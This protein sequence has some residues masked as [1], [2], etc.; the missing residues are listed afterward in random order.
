MK[1]AIWETRNFGTSRRSSGNRQR[2]AAG[3]KTVLSPLVARNKDGLTGP[4]KEPRHKSLAG[5]PSLWLMP[6]D[7][8]VAQ[9]HLPFFQQVREQG[10]KGRAQA[11]VG[12]G[13]ELHKGS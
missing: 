6:R 12:M 5:I 7:T 9:V 2:E 11:G 4:R 3:R 13:Q 1:T 10:T 8:G